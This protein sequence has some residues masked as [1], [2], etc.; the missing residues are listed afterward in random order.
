M[1]F[2]TLVALAAAVV[3]A[4]AA[5]TATKTLQPRAAFCGQWDSVQTGT[6]TLYN[7]LWGRDSGSGSQCT[8]A[9]AASGSS[10]TWTTSWSWS[11]GQYNV[12]SYANAVLKASVV[13]LSKIK[14]MPTS[15]KW[16]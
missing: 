15:W 4:L 12:K 16:R 7:N 8:E 2:A 5:P 1:R 14:S 3:P 13:Q 10:I 11:G 9:T 6:F